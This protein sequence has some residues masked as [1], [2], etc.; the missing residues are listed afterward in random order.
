[1]AYQER[2]DVRL[3]QGLAHELFGVDPGQS[4]VASLS[5]LCE[6]VERDRSRI[7]V[8]D[9]RIVNDVQDEEPVALVLRVIA[10]RARQAANADLVEVRF[11]M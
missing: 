8:G 1:M 6:R 5:G 7:R 9:Y 10:R 11:S 2:R 4:H 3:A